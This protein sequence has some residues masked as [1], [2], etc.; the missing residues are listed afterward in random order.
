MHRKIIDGNKISVDFERE[1]IMEGWKPRK[2]GGG[3]GGNITSGQLRFGGR[4][5]PFR[6]KKRR[7]LDFSSLSYQCLKT[8]DHMDI[9]RKRN[10][11]YDYERYRDSHY[12][13]EQRQLGNRKNRRRK[14]PRKRV[15]VTTG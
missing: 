14:N 3:F 8:R 5:K 7:R 10:S 11:S 15:R 4:D 12:Q 2:L 1:R 9:P 6:D 13:G